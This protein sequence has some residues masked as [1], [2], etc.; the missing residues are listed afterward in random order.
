[1]AK[2]IKN[3]DTIEHTYGGQGIPAGESYTMQ[4][5]DAIRFTSDDN[6]LADIANGK[7]QMN[8]GIADVAGVAAQISFLNGEIK[9]VTTQFEK[10]DKTVKLASA[11]QDVG[12]DSKATILIKVP[13]TPGSGDG[14]WI[15]GGI[16]WFDDQH[17]D[18]RIVGVYFSDEDDILGYGAGTAVGSYTDDEVL[19]GQQGWRIPN[20][21]GM[22]EV[23]ALGGYGFAPAGFYLKI[24]GKKGGDITTGTLYLNI[25]WGKVE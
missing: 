17:K 2:I 15:S 22:I 5:A 20:K 11:Q 9:E 10:R 6:L 19:E 14:R 13:G 1:M 21:R 24:V 25:E 3:I 12:N 18:D 4:P 23:E 8:D 7:A 16:A